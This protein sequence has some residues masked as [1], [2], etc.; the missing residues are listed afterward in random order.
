[1]K[2]NKSVSRVVG[3]MEL[4]AKNKKPLTLSE[5]S[6]ELDIPKSS[7]F[8]IVYTLV[9]KEYLEVVDER[10]KT[11]KL[12]MK[13]FEIGAS[14][15]TQTDL[16]SVARPLLDNLMLKTGE[17]IFLA[18]E[19]KGEIVYL[20]KVESNRTTIRSSANL[21]SRNKMYYTGLGKALL[22]TYSNERV[23]DIL[24][25]EELVSRTAHTITN[26]DD[27]L[28]DLEETRER[29]YAIDDRE[30]EIEIFCIAAPIFDRTNQ[31]VGAL[32]TALLY[33]KI[34][35]KMLEHI[36]SLVVQTALE[37]SHKLG[38]I[39]DRLYQKID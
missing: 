8:E 1:M 14:I 13:T 24:A 34:D 18:V 7:T 6:R 5:I 10:S 32:S 17:T 36:S 31:A 30:S 19:D 22:S 33:L 20:D 9:A 27:L 3:I 39:G 37:I 15:L 26:I 4:L 35:D 11:F 23:R 12:G 21:G 29:G 16:H 25:K 2:L 38:Y 28:A